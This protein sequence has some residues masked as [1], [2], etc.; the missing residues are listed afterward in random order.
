[1]YAILASGQAK[2]WENNWQCTFITIAVIRNLLALK[3]ERSG[4]T[5]HEDAM[6]GNSPPL[7]SAH[8]W[9]RRF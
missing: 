9:T 2:Q 8:P 5:E 7:P 4:K 1:M 6:A 3:Y